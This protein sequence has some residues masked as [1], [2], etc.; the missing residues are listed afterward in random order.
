MEPVKVERQ[1]KYAKNAAMYDVFKPTPLLA[2]QGRVLGELAHQ[3]KP[4]QKRR[5]SH[6]RQADLHHGWNQASG[7]KLGAAACSAIN[8]E[9]ASG[10]W[11]FR[12]PPWSAD[13]PQLWSFFSA[14]ATPAP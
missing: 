5:L 14:A 8:A 6:V 9:C 12:D 3:F 2:H 11:K 10:S 1:E 4:V 13:R 7:A